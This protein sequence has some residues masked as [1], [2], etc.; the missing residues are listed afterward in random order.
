ML[1]TDLAEPGAAMYW[2][3]VA[4]RF[5]PSRVARP[6]PAHV[7][8]VEDHRQVRQVM[9][10][11]LRNAGMTVIEAETAG[12]ARDALDGVF[13]DAAV[14]DI[15]L[16]GD[17]DGVQL[18]RWIRL[19]N[20]ALPMIF[21][22]GLTDW[23]LPQDIPQDGHAVLLRKPFGAREIVAFVSRMLTPRFGESG[24]HPA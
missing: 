2:R 11:A 19:R 18:G 3:P 15:S 12:G 23:E 7:L 1:P 10:R 16:P 24:L 14:L 5:D 20:R 21:V 9:A 6:I 13:I 17:M 4:D 8:L 22:T